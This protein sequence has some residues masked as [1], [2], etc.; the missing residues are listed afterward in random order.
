M[1][2]QWHFQGSVRNNGCNCKSPNKCPLLGKCL[3][4]SLVYQAT[5]TTNGNKPD[6][7]YIG[8]TS[9]TFKTR[10]ANHK[11]S[12]TNVKKKHTTELSKHVWQLKD[13][14]IDNK[15]K[16]EIIKQASPYNNTS[17]RSYYALGKKYLITCHPSPA[18]LNKRNKLISSC[19]HA[20]KYFLLRNFM[21]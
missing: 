12:F 1:C 7:T 16:W 2:Y 15:I 9:N 6:Q 11:T 4:K 18:T 3:A 14:H 17:N 8:L 10:F 5:V 21:T 19:R 13:K 20:N